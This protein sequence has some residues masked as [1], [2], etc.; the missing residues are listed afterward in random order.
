MGEGTSKG[1]S[2]IVPAFWRQ[3]TWGQ[4][5]LMWYLKSNHV[6]FANDRET[7]APAECLKQL[8]QGTETGEFWLQPKDLEMRSPT[9]LMGS[10]SYVTI[11][12]NSLVLILQKSSVSSSSVPD[13]QAKIKPRL[14]PEQAEFATLQDGEPAKIELYT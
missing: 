9:C 13:P 5:V 10:W 14:A 3:R 12:R 11:L 4:K 7:I 8:S 2:I 1:G 6:F